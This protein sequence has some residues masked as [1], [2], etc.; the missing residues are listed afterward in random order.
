METDSAERHTALQCAATALH[1]RTQEPIGLQLVFRIANWSSK[2]GPVRAMRASNMQRGKRK[3][4]QRRTCAAEGAESQTRSGKE[5]D[6]T[7]NR[8]QLDI[9]FLSANR[10]RI[11]PMP[12]LCPCPALVPLPLHIAQCT[13]NRAACSGRPC[14][15][16]PSSRQV[17]SLVWSR[18]TS[19]AAVRAR[20][21]GRSRRASELNADWL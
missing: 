17:P 8:L 11:M 21:L 18:L 20:C 5:A 12:M 14:S 13:T 7:P 6:K 1:L 3:S 10:P 19:S 9:F 2:P 15:M 4:P 16:P